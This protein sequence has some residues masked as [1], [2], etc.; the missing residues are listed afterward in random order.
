MDLFKESCHR[1]KSEDEVSGKKNE[2]KYSLHEAQAF[3][4]ERSNSRSFGWAPSLQILAMGM[5]AAGRN[6][7][8]IFKGLVVKL[9]FNK[10]FAGHTVI[11]PDSES[12]ILGG[13]FGES[14][15]RRK[16]D[17]VMMENPDFE[18][19]FSVY[20]TNDQ[21]ARY[22]ITPKL[23]ELVLEAQALLGAELRLCFSE[24]SLFVT[25]PQGKDRFEV[26]L[27][28]GPITPETALG[29]LV[30]VVNLAERLVETL[31][32]ETRIWTKV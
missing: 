2:V 26:A 27:F 6:Q 30:D 13:L 32:L 5:N 10:N 24:N 28:G 23:M 1:W 31:D 8:V 9:D 4:K 15:S 17:L 20:S 21:E 7:A 16:K 18:N 11:I 19:V 22:L 12:Q 29:D 14:R 3:R 25:V